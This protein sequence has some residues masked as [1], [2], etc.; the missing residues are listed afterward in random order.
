MSNNNNLFIYTDI[1]YNLAQEYVY[2]EFEFHKRD[3]ETEKNEYFIPIYNNILYLYLGSIL[4]PEVLEV[5]ERGVVL[6]IPGSSDNA[7]IT[8]IYLD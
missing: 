7:A 3:G 5:N 1:S 4:P 8:G 2:I 6:K